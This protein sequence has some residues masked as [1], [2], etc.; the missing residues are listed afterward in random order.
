MPYVKGGA[1]PAVFTT[2]DEQLH[3][4]LKSPIAPLYSLS[5]AVTF[6]RFIDEVLGILFEQLDKRFA[7]TGKVFDL[8]DWVQ[9]FAFEVMGTMTFSNRYGFLERGTDVNGMLE[10]IWQFMLTVGPVS[11]SIPKWSLS[12]SMKDS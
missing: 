1:L 11:T 7:G 2:Q 8:G 4:S 3:K 9:Y 6:E 10:A 5:S 12:K